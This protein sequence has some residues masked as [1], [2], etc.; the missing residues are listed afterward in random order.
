MPTIVKVVKNATTGTIFA[1][2][3]KR[4]PTSG[5]ATKAGIKVIHPTSAKIIVETRMFDPPINLFILSGGIK[6]NIKP[7]NNA[8]VDRPLSPE[9]YG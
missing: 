1:P 2:E 5:K 3:F 6:V 9:P 7:I 8:P 4:D